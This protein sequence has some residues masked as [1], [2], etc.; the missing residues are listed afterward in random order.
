MV[1][2]EGTWFCLS[3]W[4]SLEMLPGNWDLRKGNSES[5]LL[6]ALVN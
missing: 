3:H 2:V 5:K 4:F 6:F 1:G